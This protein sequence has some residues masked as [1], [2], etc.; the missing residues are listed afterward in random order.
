M[1]KQTE[2][3]ISLIKAGHNTEDVEAIASTVMDSDGSRLDMR[4]ATVQR[5]LLAVPEFRDALLEGVNEILDKREGRGVQK[6]E[7]VNLPQA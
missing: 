1:E 7:I 3:L 5:A 6:V 4:S 2:F